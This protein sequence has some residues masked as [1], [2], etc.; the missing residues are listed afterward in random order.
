MHFQFQRP[1]LNLLIFL[2]VFA[3]VT[4]CQSHS[5][6][7]LFG[8]FAV[9]SA[10]PKAGCIDTLAHKESVWLDLATPSMSMRCETPPNPTNAVPGPAAICPPMLNLGG[11]CYFSS[12]AKAEITAQISNSTGGRP[13]PVAIVGAG[14]VSFDTDVK[15]TT[16]IFCRNG[17]F[18]F[19][20]AQ[21]ALKCATAAAPT[22]FNTPCT[23]LPGSNTLTLTI[24]ATDSTG[25]KVTPNY[26]ATILVYK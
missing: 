1:F 19:G 15:N 25:A 11:N 18:Q 8:D 20:I 26:Q 3:L 2:S 17:R 16:G 5:E 23:F 24:T 7:P 22:V 14:L 21:S 12:F 6:N 10:C 9:P 4:S 13:T